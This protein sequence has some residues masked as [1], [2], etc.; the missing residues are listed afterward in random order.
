MSPRILIN[1]LDKDQGVWDGKRASHHCEVSPTWMTKV[2]LNEKGWNGAWAQEQKALA[3]GVSTLQARLAHSQEQG[4][5]VSIVQGL[6]TELAVVPIN[7]LQGRGS[8][9]LAP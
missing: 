4:K 1:H 9:L 2:A 8:R 6:G 3:C 7:R 5:G